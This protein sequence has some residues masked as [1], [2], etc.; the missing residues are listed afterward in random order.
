[1]AYYLHVTNAILSINRRQATEL[2]CSRRWNISV[3]QKS[4]PCTAGRAVLMHKESTVTMVFCFKDLCCK[5]LKFK[6]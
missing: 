6:L 5:K 4:V 2:I 1:M 3:M